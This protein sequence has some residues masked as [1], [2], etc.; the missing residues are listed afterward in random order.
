MVVSCPTEQFP[1]STSSPNRNSIKTAAKRF[2]F[3]KLSSGL[4]QTTEVGLATTLQIHLDVF[5]FLTG[6]KSDLIPSYII[7]HSLIHLHVNA[8]MDQCALLSMM[9]HL[10]TFPVHPRYN[11][12]VHVICIHGSLRTAEI[13]LPH[14]RIIRPTEVPCPRGSVA[15]P[16]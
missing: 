6:M 8:T 16:T 14:R 2:Y 13:A 3:K 10:L 1:F 15:M 5:F 11:S 12:A 9:P 4:V 7:S